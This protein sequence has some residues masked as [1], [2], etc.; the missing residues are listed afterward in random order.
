MPPYKSSRTILALRAERRSGIVFGSS[1][2]IMEDRNHFSFPRS[3]W[4][5]TVGR[6]ASKLATRSVETWV[7]TRSVGTRGLFFQVVP[8]FLLAFFHVQCQLAVEVV[9]LRNH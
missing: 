7:P 9:A 3:A 2:S 1:L 8:Q 4:E 5:R 6:S